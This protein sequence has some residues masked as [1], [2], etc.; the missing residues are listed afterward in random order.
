MGLFDRWKKRAVSADTA[1]HQRIDEFWSSV[2]ASEP[3]LLAYAISPSLQG[4]PHWPS[5]RQAY[6]VVR[7]TSSIII[8]TDGMSDPFDG[9]VSTGDG[10]G[11]GMELFI[12][13]T[14]IPDAF[15]GR[16]GDVSQ[17][18][19][20]WAFELLRHIGQDIA[21]QGGIVDRLERLGALTMELPG[22]SQSAVLVEQLPTTFITQDDCIGILLGAPKPEFPD[23]IVDMPLSPVRLVPLVVL[24][25]R[26]L[27]FV[28]AGGASA[29]AELVEK[30]ASSPSRHRSDL[31]RRS[32]V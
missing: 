17:I 9:V 14:D 18:P 6:R 30:L 28:R 10:N 12:E 15:A 27:E 24:T 20:C 26:E 22:F 21:E 23:Q 3:D 5:M 8:A 11:F 31:H 4:K 16:P 25:S 13:T 1:T 7:R 29:R 19:K 32:V 2:G